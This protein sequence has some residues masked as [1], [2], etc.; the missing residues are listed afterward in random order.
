MFWL[1][2]SEI[3]AVAQCSVWELEGLETVLTPGRL[4]NLERPI[5][6]WINLLITIKEA[7]RLELQ[8]LA[9]GHTDLQTALHLH[10]N[11]KMDKILI[12]L[13]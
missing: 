11:I 3:Q 10:K 6:I 2:G 8:E 1:G 12:R 13:M 5:K 4:R 7:K 9:L